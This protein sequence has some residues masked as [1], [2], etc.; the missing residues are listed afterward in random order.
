MLTE[1]QKKIFNDGSKFYASDGIEYSIRFSQPKKALCLR[2]QYR[3]C[4]DLESIF[5]GKKNLMFPLYTRDDNQK[6]CLILI[7]GFGSK[8][9]GTYRKLARR[10]SAKGIDSLVY[11]LPLHF[12]RMADKS[13]L[14]KPQFSHI[15]EL[16]RQALIELRLLAGYLKRQGYSRVGCLGFSFGGYCCNLLACFEKNI[17]FIISIASLGDLG[18][19]Y[20]YMMK[21]LK[22]EEKRPHPAPATKLNRYLA[23]HYI[24]LI[25]PISFKPHISAQKIL[26]IQGLLDRRTPVGGVRRLRKAWGHPRVVWLPCDHSSFILFHRIM[27]NIASNYIASL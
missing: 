7:H 17:D 5:G 23:Q 21:Y 24:W 4:L 25:S 3:P 27:A 16:Y 9:K 26:L 2:I 12:E 15:F 19:I 22:L 8:R 13:F 20:P 18:P 11:T 10:F 6:T 14:E 1:K